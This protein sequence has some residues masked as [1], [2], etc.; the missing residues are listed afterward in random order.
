MCRLAEEETEL[1]LIGF[2][3]AFP[4]LMQMAKNLG[5]DVPSDD[6]FVQNINAMRDIKLKRFSKVSHIVLT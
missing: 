3:I 4:S 1:M 2:E 6:P 5:L